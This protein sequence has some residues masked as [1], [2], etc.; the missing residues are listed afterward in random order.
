M[1]NF[2]KRGARWR[3]RIRRDGV[4]YSETFRTKTEAAAWAA[5][6]EAEI[7]GGKIGR[8]PD[9]SFG[10][11]L[12]RYLDEV[13]PGHGA[14]HWEAVQIRRLLGESRTSTPDPLI[15]V[16]LPDLAPTHFT[17]WRDRRLATVKASTV[18][19]ERNLL[20]AICGA[21]VKE[22]RWLRD[23]PVKAAPMPKEPPPRTRRIHPDEVEAILLAC[24]YDRESPP[25][26]KQARVA[27]AFLWAIETAMRAG[28]ICALRWSDIDADARTARIRAVEQ[29]AR[30]TGMGRTVPLSSEAMR[31]LAQLRG[32]DADR[33][34]G[35]GSPIL[36]ALFRKARDRAMVAGLHF[37][38]SRAEALTRL[39]K[40]LDV[41]QLARVSGHK[42]VRLLFEVYYR[43]SAA[44]MVKLL[45]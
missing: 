21:A 12:R 30:K 25:M 1:A 6:R 26:T 18:L 14:S 4:D 10:E 20:S 38:D 5:Q 31:L 22:W 24:G 16:R 9:R 43:E 13:T 44:D 2:E 28:E 35:L 32:I 34:F 42:D 41:M 8:V 15:H 23:N 37:H 39:S 40:K 17:A 7:D 3:V 33:V 36:D 27:A 19:R 29:G 11:L 45:D